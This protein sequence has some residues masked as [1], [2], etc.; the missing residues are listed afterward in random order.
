MSET[1][2]RMAP[3]ASEHLRIAARGQHI[4]R[5]TS[6]RTK[7]PSGRAGG[8]HRCVAAGAPLTPQ[9]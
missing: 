4:E 1:L 6:P 3:N 9:I 5:W 8:R 2:A 7:Y